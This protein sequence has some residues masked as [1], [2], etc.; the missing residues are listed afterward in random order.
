MVRGRNR[1]NSRE[2]DSINA[3]LSAAGF[4]LRK[5]LATEFYVLIF[6]SSGGSI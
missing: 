2:S 3:A 1:L 6:A 4:N 5:L